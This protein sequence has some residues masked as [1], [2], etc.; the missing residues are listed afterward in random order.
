MVVRVDRAFQALFRR[1]KTGET[2]GDPRLQGRTP[3]PLEPLH[4]SAGGRARRWAR[5]QVRD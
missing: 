1:V 4:L 5:T 2:P 3:H